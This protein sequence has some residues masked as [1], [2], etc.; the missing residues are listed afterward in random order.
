MKSS[1]H[2]N[3]VDLKSRKFTVIMQFHKVMDNYSIKQDPPINMNY[4]A[5]KAHFLL[6]GRNNRTIKERVQ[7]SYHRLPYTHL[8]QMLIKYLVTEATK[9]LN[10]FK[11]NM[12][13]PN[14]S[15]CG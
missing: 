10:F 11:T 2:T 8:P 15:A 13:S 7:A 12:V 4:A 9:K 1:V 6:A 3:A 5:A 14:T